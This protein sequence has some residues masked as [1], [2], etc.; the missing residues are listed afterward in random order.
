MPLLF[1]WAFPV[2]FYI[3]MIALIGVWGVLICRILYTIAYKINP[4]A[5]AGPGFLMLIL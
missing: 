1:L 4:G 5:R 3:P 2:S